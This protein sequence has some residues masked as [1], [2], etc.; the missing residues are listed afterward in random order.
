[1]HC[2]CKW[3]TSKSM[4][5]FK[6]FAELELFLDKIYETVMEGYLW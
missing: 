2:L 4:L 6:K 3:Y 1:M 5:H